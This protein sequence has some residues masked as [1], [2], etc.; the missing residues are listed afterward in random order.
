MTIQAT[1]TALRP[2]LTLQ[3]VAGLL[4]VH[5][6]TVSRYANSGEMRCV[7]IGKR[8]MFEESDVVD[9]IKSRKQLFDNQVSAGI[10]MGKGD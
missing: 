1:H 7:L 6:T 8:L 9:F 4:G 5:R 2:L 10:V 3:Q